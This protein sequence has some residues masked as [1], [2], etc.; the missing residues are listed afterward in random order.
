MIIHNFLRYRKPKPSSFARIF[1]GKKRIENMLQI[2][3]LDTFPIILNSY[4]DFTCSFTCVYVYIAFIK[5]GVYGIDQY[6]KKHLVNLPF[7]TQNS[8]ILFAVF[9]MYFYAVFVLII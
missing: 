1:C 4:F 6:I 2:T 3:R 7:I 8:K 9:P 5:T